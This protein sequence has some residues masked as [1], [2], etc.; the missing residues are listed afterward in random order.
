MIP[1]YGLR[2]WRRIANPP[3]AASLHY[4]GCR[5][6]IDY[7]DRRRFVG[8]LA[9]TGVAAPQVR[10]AGVAAPSDVTR[11]LAR[12]VVGARAEDLPAGVRRE[13]ARTFLN[14]VGCAVGGAHD[15]AVDIV[16]AAMSPFA[17]TGQATLLGRKERMDVMNAALV[18]GVSSHIFDYDDTHL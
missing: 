13:A 8:S 12:W 6:T 2:G 18:N 3:Q 1:G 15:P 4:R 16:V 9:L 14:W 5:H 10:A 17:G 7:V 11:T